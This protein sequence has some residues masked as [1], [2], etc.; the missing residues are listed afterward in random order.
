M[1]VCPASAFFFFASGSPVALLS[2]VVMSYE[3]ERG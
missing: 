2:S 3:R 1:N